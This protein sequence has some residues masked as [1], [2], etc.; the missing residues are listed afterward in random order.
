MPTRRM[1]N[2]R[3]TKEIAPR[4]AL[5]G[6]LYRNCK[7]PSDAN[8]YETRRSHIDAVGSRNACVAWNET[9]VRKPPHTHR[10][11]KI[12]ARGTHLPELSMRRRKWIARFAH[13][14]F[15]GFSWQP[16]IWYWWVWQLECQTFVFLCS[17][18]VFCIENY[19]NS[20]TIYSSTTFFPLSRA[21]L[22][23]WPHVP[24][25]NNAA[26]RSVQFHFS[27]VGNGRILY[28]HWMKV[29]LLPAMGLQLNG[30][31]VHLNTLPNDKH[32]TVK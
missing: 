2:W 20:S 9:V 17:I 15:R 30:S 19:W 11:T 18:A 32:A 31:Y 27:A 6:C 21:L 14:N 1:E 12:L 25:S 16:L 22:Q 8:Q 3:Q 13:S 23:C 24:K 28:S 29:S 4:H 26:N 7:T 10:K 5:N